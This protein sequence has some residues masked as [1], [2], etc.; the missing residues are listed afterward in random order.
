MDIKKLASLAMQGAS[1]MGANNEKTQQ[2]INQA[3][4][5]AQNIQTKEQALQ[6]IKNLGVDNSFIDKAIAMLD[7]PLAQGVTKTLGIDIDI[8]DTKNKLNSLK[9]GNK[10]TMGNAQ[11]QTSNSNNSDPLA[12]LRKGLQRR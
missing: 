9:T 8:N 7:N 5:I 4:P 11:S 2:A 6:A 1:L 3:M 12:S 10:T